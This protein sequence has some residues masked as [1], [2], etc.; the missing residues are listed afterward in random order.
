MK[1]ILLFTL[2]MTLGFAVMAQQ[3][4]VKSNVVSQKA[5]FAEEV[6][7]APT[8]NGTVGM[9]YK[10]H[11][12]AVYKSTDVVSI[13]PIGTSVNGFSYGYGGGQKSI[14]AANNDINT[15]TH[16]HRMGGALDPDGYSGDLGYD[17]STDGG[18]TW[19]NMVEFYTATNNAGGSYFTDAARYPNHGIFNPAGNTDPN[20][21]YVSY[22]APTLDGSNSSDSWGGYG[23]GRASIGDI[24]DTTK[25]LETSKPADNLFQYTP[26]G[27]TTTGNGH[28]WSSDLNQDWRSGAVVFLN[29][30]IVNHGVWN[31]SIMDFDYEQYT[32]ECI[33]EPGVTRPAQSKVEFSPD[34]QIGYYAVLADN[35]EIDISKGVSYFP[36]IWRTEDAGL[37]WS[38]AISVA[39]AGD[40]GIA[41]VLNYL[42]DTEIGELFNPPLPERE[43]IPFTTA[44]DFDLSVDTYGNPQIAV[45]VGVT[46]STPYSISTGISPS[47]RYAFTSAFLLSSMDKGNEGSWVGYP[48]GRPVSFRGNFGD[49]SEDNRIQIA[50]THDGSK[51]FVAWLDTDTTISG[52]N[53]AP[54][55]W[56]RGVDVINHTYTVDP[57]GAN[58]DR[59]VNVTWGSS[60]TF[61]AYFFAMGNEVLEDGNGN[62]TIPFTYQEML[63]INDPVQYQYIQ[64]FSFNDADFIIVGM[65]EKPV[66]QKVAATVSQTSPNPAMGQARFSVTLPQTMQVKVM[67]VNMMGQTVQTLPARTLQ[68]GA[69]EITLDVSSLPAGVYFYTVEAGSETITKKMIVK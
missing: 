17:I 55:I 28:F 20:N 25:H 63:S 69:N 40:D 29:E 24:T 16:V 62:Y 50:R 39:L 59:P 66:V 38:D 11:K 57:E 44:F 6:A 61:S 34:G 41:G 23:W 42:S 60:A 18:V 48:L 45:I 8:N 27:Y 54:D 53:N 58:P 21:A 51:M 26:D 5:N 43:E 32:L 68:A 52:E 10:I 65:E 33:L 15:I 64:D 14:L 46:G 30:V 3:A 49:N 35:G 9:D 37:T 19:T 67:L 47:S 2:A 7:Y 13:I 36:I 12:P 31:E 1:R 56:T 22:L 4:R